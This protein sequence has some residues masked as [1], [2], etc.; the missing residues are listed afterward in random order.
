MIIEY[1]DELYPERLRE[2]E[3][4]PSRLY[5]LG[6]V[7]ILN[8]YGIAVV[9][10]RTNTHYGEIMCKTFTKELV[11]YNLNIISGLAKGIDSIAHN[12][13]LKN[14]GKTI[15]VLPCGLKN[16]YPTTNISLAKNILEN[17]G[18]LI[19]E[20]EDNIKADSKKFRERNRI[21]AG[22]AI[23][24]LVIEAGERSGTSITAN[25]TVNQGKQVF[26]IPS[27]LENKKGKTTN[28]L[29]KK[30]AKLVTKVEDI[31]NTYKHIEFEKKKIIHKEINIDI[32]QELL[33]VYK[34]IRNEPVD[35]NQIS[36]LTGLSIAQ[37]NYKTMMLELEDK[38]ITLP[39]QRFLRKE[40]D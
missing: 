9:G 29:I 37:I 3:N 15:A 39:G 35:V 20:Y 32:S 4:P 17:G 30:G 18:V 8:N 6:N 38:I 12:T 7:E 36:I 5:V 28:N 16:I 19:S 22:L 1:L 25:Y 2:L 24:T 13:C 23:G 11:K 21:V 14:S 10:S 26:A 31:L 40:D 34:V 27:S 33:D